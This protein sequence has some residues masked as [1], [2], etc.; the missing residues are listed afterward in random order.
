[1]EKSGALDV[2]YSCEHGGSSDGEGARNREG[3]RHG[4]RTCEGRC[5]RRHSE[6]TVQRERF[7]QKRDVLG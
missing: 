2:Q 1:M 5:P 7:V 6:S 4:Y 3:V